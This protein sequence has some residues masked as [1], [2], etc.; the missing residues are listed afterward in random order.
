[1][2]GCE[3]RSQNFVTSPKSSGVASTLASWGRESARASATVR[4]SGG[5][6]SRVCYAAG[7][8]APITMVRDR[9]R[10]VCSFHR[11]RGPHVCPNGKLVRREVLEQLLLRA[12]RQEFLSPAKLV[13]LTRRV[14]EARARANSQSTSARRTLVAQLREAER[15]AEHIKDAVRQGKATLTLLGMLE[16]NEA[17]IQRLRTDLNAPP[18]A[19]GAVHALPG[20]VERSVMDLWALLDR[21]TDRARFLLQRLLGEIVLRPDANG[22]VAEMSGNL[23]VILESAGYGSLAG[24]GSPVFLVPHELLRVTYRNQLPGNR[25]RAER[26]QKCWPKSN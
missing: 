24:A 16:E 26:V 20:L 10:Y 6:S 8:V 14:N 18:K 7:S 2:S 23:N 3:W 19:K 15:E 12:I 25:P 13:Y 22:L 17:K 9:T 1:M 5:I 11:N 21:V 4:R